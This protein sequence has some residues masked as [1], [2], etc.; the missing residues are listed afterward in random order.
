MGIQG[1]PAPQADIQGKE[2][3][4]IKKSFYFLRS[5]VKIPRNIG[6]KKEQK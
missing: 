2:K 1:V 4:K 6:Q 5:C 3:G